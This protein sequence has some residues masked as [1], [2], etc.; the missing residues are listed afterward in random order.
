MLALFVLSMLTAI[1]TGFSG[2]ESL[3]Q[4]GFIAL[5]G[6]TLKFF[7]DQPI[8]LRKTEGMCMGKRIIQ[9]E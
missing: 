7:R 2:D 9:S 8:E 3:A 6:D 1:Y 5:P 4:V